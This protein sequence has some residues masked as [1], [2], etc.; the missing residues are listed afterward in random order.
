MFFKFTNE[1]KFINL[2]LLRGET[3]I[4]KKQDETVS[5]LELNCKR[6]FLLLLQALFD[7][8]TFSLNKKQK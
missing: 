7:R 6:L 1:S 2:C 3:W 4:M 5:R 8:E